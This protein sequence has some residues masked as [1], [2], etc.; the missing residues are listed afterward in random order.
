MPLKFSDDN[1]GDPDV[2]D[3][4]HG[5]DCD[6]C[7]DGGGGH[8]HSVVVD[9]IPRDNHHKP[10]KAQVYKRLAAVICIQALGYRK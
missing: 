9:N 7:N 8:G 1:L 3:S 4:G 6:G 10:P 5:A 2:R